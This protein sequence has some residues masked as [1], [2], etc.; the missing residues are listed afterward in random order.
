MYGVG[1]GDTGLSLPP[2]VCVK[3]MFQHA[4]AYAGIRMIE[5][6][7]SVQS[8]RDVRADECTDGRER[9]QSATCADTDDVEAAMGRAV[10]TCVQVDVGQCVELVHDD[11]DVV[12]SDACRH[13]GDAFA[14]ACSGDGMKFPVAGLAFLRI[15]V[16]GDEIDTVRVS[17]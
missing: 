14:A 10:G 7:Q 15:Q 1:I 4:V 13:D 2:H 6:Q 16:R 11:V 8:D 17:H 3:L 5:I 9:L 12:T